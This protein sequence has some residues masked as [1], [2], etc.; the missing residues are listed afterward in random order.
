MSTRIENFASYAS[1]AAYWDNDE[2]RLPGS[3]LPEANEG[4]C[5]A[6]ALAG[7]QSIL[8][9]GDSRSRQLAEEFGGFFTPHSRKQGAHVFT[10]AGHPCGNRT[11]RY[12]HEA[13]CS[14][15]TPPSELHCN[16]TIRVSFMA[17]WKYTMPC[18]DNLLAGLNPPDLLV[19]SAGL[20]DIIYA[21]PTEY[22][23]S[24]L[25]AAV[26]TMEPR[27]I[28]YLTTAPICPPLPGR[29][30]KF[31]SWNAV[32]AKIATWRLF[33]WKTATSAGC[34]VVDSHAL[35]AAQCHN[36]YDTIHFGGRV[37]RDIADLL[38]RSV[39][40]SVVSLRLPGLQQDRL[41]AQLREF[42]V[43]DPDVDRA[44]G[45][46]GLLGR[47]MVGAEWSSIE[48]LAM[49]RS[50]LA[51]RSHWA[52]FG[53]SVTAHNQI[54]QAVSR[55]LQQRGL[56]NKVSN[57]GV[58]ATGPDYLSYC[59]NKVVGGEHQ[60]RVYDVIV[61]EYSENDF[62]SG[63][64]LDAL[65]AASLRLPQQ[66]VVLMYL[67]CGPRTIVQHGGCDARHA[68]HRAIARRHGIVAIDLTPW[69][70]SLNVSDH[71]KYFYD[72]VHPTKQGG[73]AMGQF[74][75]RVMHQ[76]L[77]TLHV[78]EP[79]F[80]PASNRSAAF[81]QHRTSLSTEAQRTR[82]C[83]TT[84]AAEEQRNLQPMQPAPGWEFVSEVRGRM[85][86]SFHTLSKNGWQNSNDSQWNTTFT[87]DKSFSQPGFACIQFRLD[88]CSV[89][90]VV[91]YLVTNVNPWFGRANISIYS[92]G[93]LGSNVHSVPS[94][95]NVTLIS[96]QA[97]SGTAQG[98][99]IRKTD[100]MMRR[101]LLPSLAARRTSWGIRVCP[102]QG[103]FRVIAI[104]CEYRNR[105]A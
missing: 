86:G 46:A 80:G 89:N 72:S 67:H 77:R 4:R 33:E 88:E 50:M 38:L 82:H 29:A 92:I 73:D 104:G 61:Y 28:I 18:F 39:V 16:G 98:T 12:T 57:F 99:A 64:D 93:P 58:P 52:W 42:T 79:P 14:T 74:I 5:R 94:I 11:Y 34:G 10:Y 76:G 44:H 21:S 101:L 32:N 43:R 25:E 66:P 97:Y 35:Y 31:S 6:L 45:S 60:L 22:V 96:N 30:A 19:L 15:A 2:L 84:L 87:Y 63:E 56:P 62:G 59:L 78:L 7:V 75:V 24:R 65:V 26:A 90:V 81:A 13:K 105:G 91:Y 102:V 103:L 55:S 37:V 69:I 47:S 9:A 83:W 23:G 8:F 71:P 20:H 3:S 54:V 41:L 95:S 68:S 51:R 100:A 36:S 48:G 27:N 17:C 49:A 70:V 1:D 53:G 40:N 85:A